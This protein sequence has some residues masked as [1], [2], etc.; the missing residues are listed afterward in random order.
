MFAAAPHESG[1]GLTARLSA[2]HTQGAT[3]W[4]TPVEDG[5]RSDNVVF[6]PQT[7]VN[8]AFRLAPG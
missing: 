2:G 5:G 3:T 6:L 8:P 4:I 7:T 1:C